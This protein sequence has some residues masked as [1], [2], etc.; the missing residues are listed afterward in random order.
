MAF[1]DNAAVFILIFLLTLLLNPCKA[2]DQVLCIPNERQALLTF[3]QH[4]LDPSNRLASWS[5]NTNCCNWT[6]IV[7]DHVTGHILRLDLKTSIPSSNWNSEYDSYDRS[8]LGGEIHLSILDLK[9]LSYLDLSGNYFEGDFPLCLKNSNKLVFLD[10]RENQF[11]RIIPPWVGDTLLNLK[12]FL[13]TS[14]KFSGK[15]PCQMYSLSS[16]HILDLAQNNLTGPLPKCINH[17]SFM[18]VKNTTLESNMY[19]EGNGAIVP[20]TN[21]LLEL[22]GR[23]DVY[24]TLG[25][26]TSIDLSNNKLFGEIPREITT[27]KG[28]HFLNLSNNLLSGEIPQSIGN[29]GSLES[30]DLSK[31]Q[32]Y[33]EIPLSMSNLNFL[34]KLNLSFNNLRGKIPMGTQLQSFEASCFVGNDLCGPPLPNNC[35]DLYSPLNHDKND[36]EAKRNEINWFFCEHVIGIC[37]RIL[38]NN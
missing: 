13:L 17:L 35:T 19:G 7:C 28:L 21:A 10:F 1:C 3:K 33:G 24:W 27:L 32:L 6:S 9:S 4:L 34:S 23:D 29:M 31:N 18:V 36:K 14:N 8:R 20:I 25:L 22:K 16:L 11:S 26:I 38:G 37:F 2:F 5:S 30:M 12:V 15:I